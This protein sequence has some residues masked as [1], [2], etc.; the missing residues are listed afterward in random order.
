MDINEI[1]ADSS[2]FTIIQLAI[3]PEADSEHENIN[4]TTNLGRFENGTNT[5]SKNVNAERKVSLPIFAN[6]EDGKATVRAEVNS[7]SRDLNFDFIKALPDLVLL[8]PAA[9]TTSSQTAYVNLELLRN[10]GRVGRNIQVYIT[11]D[12]H[13][14]NDILI[15]IPPIVVVEDKTRSIAVNNVMNTSGEISL[16]ASTINHDGDTISATS[17]L[18]FE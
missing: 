14:T 17:L 3:H 7:I 16:T 8:E 5:I 18:I 1:H 15:D 10:S 11:Y 13:D 2:S 6:I 9:L 4:F 12:Q